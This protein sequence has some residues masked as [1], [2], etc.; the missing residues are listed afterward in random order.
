MKKLFILAILIAFMGT[1]TAK[2]QAQRKCG[3]MEYLELQKADDPGLNLRIDNYEQALQQWIEKNQDYI[4]STKGTVTVPVVVHIIYNTAAQNISDTRVQEQIDVLNRDYAGL[5]THSMQAFSSSLKVNTDLQFCLAQRTPSGAATT[6]IERRQTSVTSFSYSN[7]GAK[8]YSTGGLDAWDP[9]KY[10]NIWVCPLGDGLCGYAQFPTSGVDATFG[11][12]IH[13]EFFGVTGATAPYNLGGTTTHEIGHC[14]N[15][16][17]IWGDDGGTCTGSDYCTDVPNQANYTYGVHTGVLT[18]KCTAK[19]PGIMYMNF[20][21]YSD[22]ISYANF[23]PNQKAR[24]AAL[25][26][27]GGLLYSL[28]VSDGC[29]APG[30][31]A[32]GTPSGLS[33]TGIT[34]TSATLNWAA[35]SGA[36][37]YNIQYRPSG[38]STFVTT[39]STT[40]S[41]AITGLTDGT[42]YEFMVQAVCSET[43]TYS[44]LSSFTTLTAGGCTDIY[45]SN[46]TVATAKTIAVNTNINASIET[47]ADVDYYKF[48]NTSAKKKIKVTLTD[49]PADYDL[50]LF[51]SNGT[52]LIATSQNSGTTTE[53]IVYNNAKVGTYVIKVYGYNGAYSASS[54]YTLTASISSLSW[55]GVEEVMNEPD[56]PQDIMIYPNPASENLNVTYNAEN[57]GDVQ[58]SIYDLAGRL[59]NSTSYQANKGLNNYSMSVSALAKGIYV[60]SLKNGNTLLNQKLIIDK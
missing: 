40:N 36:S 43:G 38:T 51:K 46:N 32:C 60:L 1:F 39:T 31:I 57:N 3:T 29:T 25:F 28:S 22:D 56:T 48:S 54:C 52:T 53:S 23:T 21:D 55:K 4:N 9:T 2:V 24:I 11:V 10:M 12:V 34:T 59:L 35:V 44:G 16:Y 15:L 49:L 6:G 41:K 19:S 13:Y 7:D 30:T 26:A 47:A 58:I 33:A 18:D 5:N 17:H 42:I 45:E 14:F 27:S 8:Y 37:S 50:K 20:M